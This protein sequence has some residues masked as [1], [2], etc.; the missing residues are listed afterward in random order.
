MSSNPKP[1]QNVLRLALS[2]TVHLHLSCK[3]NLVLKLALVLKLSLKLR[4]NLNLALNLLANKLALIPGGSV[5]GM[6]C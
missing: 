4:L 2:S 3:Q 6:R 1:F 5:Q